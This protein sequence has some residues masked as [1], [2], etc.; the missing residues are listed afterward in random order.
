MLGIICGLAIEAKLASKIPGA[1]VHVSA[2]SPARAQEQ[3]LAL[4]KSGVSHI[5]SFGLAAGLAPELRT[6]TV[7]VGT[8][9]QS[10]SFTYPCDKIWQQEML[11]K[12]PLARAG[13]IYGSNTLVSTPTEKAALYHKTHC[14]ALDMES[15]AIA[16]ILQKLSAPQAISQCSTGQKHLPAF[17]ILRVIADSAD[18]ALPPAARLPLKN[19]GSIDLPKILYHIAKNPLQIPALVALGH[20]TKIALS[21]LGQCTS[22]FF[23]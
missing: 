18:T 20:K 21:A 4:I 17:G 15:Q 11:Q 16:S 1:I 9:V 12:I 23:I 2:A 10:G 5:L 6:G 7:L 22:G 19:S 14:L 3:T 8:E 13:T